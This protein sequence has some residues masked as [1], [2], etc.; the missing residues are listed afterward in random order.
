[1]FS[2]LRELWR[3]AR[4]SELRKDIEDSAQRLRLAGDE[5]NYRFARY[6]TSVCKTIESQYGPLNAI[7]PEFKLKIAK[8]LRIQ[9]RAAFD[10]DQG[11]GYALFTLSAYLESLTLSG[12]DAIFVRAM[13]ASLLDAAL[14]VASGGVLGNPIQAIM[15]GDLI[16]FRRSLQSNPNFVN[17]IFEP[18]NWTLL[19]CLAALGNKALPVHSTMAQELISA[20]AEVNCRTPLGWTPIIMIAMNGQ[21]ELVP[22]ARILIA[23]G[24]DV[25]AIDNHG[26]DW[27]LHWQ[28]G[29]EIKAALEAAMTPAHGAR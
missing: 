12:S 26:M 14:E 2:K 3:G 28:H 29:Q 15:S 24:A 21:K 22:L 1:M 6:A 9:A 18:E 5:V 4:A 8:E 7:A 10:Q 23:H 17:K 27:R 25:R 19:H 20:G 16:E 11:R 13:S